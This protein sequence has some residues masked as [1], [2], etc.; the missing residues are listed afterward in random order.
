MLSVPLLLKLDPLFPYSLIPLSVPNTTST[1][2]HSPSL[3]TITQKKKK[4]KKK[5]NLK[6]KMNTSPPST[7]SPQTPSHLPLALQTYMETTL[8]HAR[9][10]SYAVATLPHHTRNKVLLTIAAEIHNQKSMLLNANAK[11]IAAAKE[12]NLAEALIDRLLLTEKRLTDLAKSVINI[13]HLQ[14]PI[15]EII[16]GKTLQNGLKLLKKRVPLGVV[17][18][19]YESRPNVTIDIAS[20]CIKSGNVAILRG[21]KE[22]FHSNKAFHKVIAAALANHNVSEHAVHVIAHTDRLLVKHLLK[23][24]QAIDIVIPRGGEAL[25]NMVADQSRIPVIY[26]DKGLCHLYVA[27]DADIETAIALTLNSKVQR[28]GVCNA[29]ETLLIH[30]DFP[31]IDKVIA[32][33]QRENVALRGDKTLTERFSNID[34]AQEAD[35]STEYLDLILSVKLV[36]STTEAIDWINTYSSHHTDSI[37]TT[38]LAL[39]QQ[40][41]AEVDS[42]CVF[43]NASTRFSDGG[44]FDMG[45]EVGVSNQKLHVRGPMGIRDLTSYKYIAYGSGHIR[46]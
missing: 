3:N 2:Y 1:I 32:A 22:A 27:A 26:H 23:Q 25:V 39:A 18:V 29:I 7:N 19:I 4:K 17:M 13:T 28:T 45:S 44:C 9:K 30:K 15:G 20:L 14:D 24:K 41:E 38:D 8:N 10:T 43:I 37:V 12:N 11:D 34:L 21:G 16:E 36:S 42:A 40:F 31:A 46:T 35:W 33:L 6:P 5:K